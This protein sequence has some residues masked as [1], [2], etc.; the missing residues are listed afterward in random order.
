MS[1]R[2]TS[3]RRLPLSTSSPQYD[4][5]QA[6]QLTVTFVC[7]PNLLNPIHPPQCSSPL[8]AFKRKTILYTLP[9]SSVYNVKPLCLCGDYVFCSL[10][11]R[12]SNVVTSF[13]TRPFIVLSYYYYYSGRYVIEKYFI[14]VL[15]FKSCSYVWWHQLYCSVLFVLTNLFLTSYFNLDLGYPCN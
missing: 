15:C 11:E 1:P 9:F 7:L 3:W 6:S 5:L 4:T 13:I 2:N 10:F 8:H 12:Q 14:W